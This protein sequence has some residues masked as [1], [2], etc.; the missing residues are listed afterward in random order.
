MRECTI[1][2]LQFYINN[3]SENTDLLAVYKED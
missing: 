1:K 2:R 3:L